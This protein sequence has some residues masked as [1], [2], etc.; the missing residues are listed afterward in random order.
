[1]RSLIGKTTLVL[2]TL[3]LAATALVGLP[4]KAEALGCVLGPSLATAAKAAGVSCPSLDGVTGPEHWGAAGGACKYGWDSTALPAGLLGFLD[5]T[6][7]SR[8]RYE[9]VDGSS[10]TGSYYRRGGKLIG[11]IIFM[12]R[13]DHTFAVQIYVWG[14]GG[15]AMETAY[16]DC[17]WPGMTYL[18][19]S[20]QAR[21]V[22]PQPGQPPASPTSTRVTARGSMTPLG[23]A[24]L[25]LRVDVTNGDTDPNF[26]DLQ[27]DLA[28]YAVDGFP[29]L[30]RGV[31][32][33]PHEG[34]TCSIDSL[35]PGQ[36]VTLVL[37]LHDAG[38]STVGDVDL[39]LSAIGMIR[40][41][42]C[43]CHAPVNHPSIVTDFYR[44]IRP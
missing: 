11:A 3:A 43:I 13:P 32:C 18:D 10:A 17:M 25:L 8:E 30:P 31:T 36:T 4:A 29:T 34:L 40:I 12:R 20:A 42:D 27:F 39:S 1:M 33:R 19:T 21:H 41:K 6:Y 16:F 2:V 14:R 37:L 24:N 26:A 5:A 7:L 9:E 28:G 35:D 38:T 22:M 15:R 23:T 44:V